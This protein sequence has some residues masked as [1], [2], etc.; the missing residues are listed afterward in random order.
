VQKILSGTLDSQGAITKVGSKRSYTLWESFDGIRKI[1]REKGLM[2]LDFL[3]YALAHTK[4]CNAFKLSA[5]IGSSVARTTGVIKAAL[6][7]IWAHPAFKR[8][9]VITETPKNWLKDIGFGDVNLV[10]GSLPLGFYLAKEHLGVNGNM[11]D[12]I[13]V[14][15]SGQYRTRDGSIFNGDFWFKD[16]RNPWL[17]IQINDNNASKIDP[18]SWYNPSRYDDIPTVVELQTWA[19]NGPWTRVWDSKTGKPLSPQAGRIS[20]KVK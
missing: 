5:S 17:V 12:V 18:D 2:P 7:G 11:A 10:S 6:P 1:S 14:A 15:P 13:E 20:L 4:P 3:D 8:S 19:P 9:G 16:K